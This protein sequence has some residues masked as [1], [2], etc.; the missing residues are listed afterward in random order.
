MQ[1]LGQ[2]VDQGMECGMVVNHIVKNV[3]LRFGGDRI[4]AINMSKD[5]GYI[6]HR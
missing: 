4:I 6:I 1:F 5:H 3:E 2:I